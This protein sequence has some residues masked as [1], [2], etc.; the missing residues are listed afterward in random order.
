M[1]YDD[2]IYVNLV[3]LVSELQKD[4]LLR[5]NLYDVFRTSAFAKKS[6]WESYFNAMIMG[7]SYIANCVANTRSQKY[8]FTE[9]K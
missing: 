6:D 5:S 4:R 2:K 1:D 8:F 3:Q 7:A 9:V